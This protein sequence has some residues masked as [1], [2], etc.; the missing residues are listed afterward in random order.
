[1]VKGG[2]QGSGKCDLKVGDGDRKHMGAVDWVCCVSVVGLI[3]GWYS[4]V[5]DINGC[6][7]IGTWLSCGDLGGAGRRARVG[8][9]GSA[10]T[11]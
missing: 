10:F 5:C 11:S 6:F 4:G 8:I 9:R 1:M 3:C 2:Y 7:P